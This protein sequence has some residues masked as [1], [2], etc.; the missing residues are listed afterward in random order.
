MSHDGTFCAANVFK[1]LAARVY[2]WLI[3][4]SIAAMI[5]LQ[6]DVLAKAFTLGVL[7]DWG[8]FEYL[9]N[10][11]RGVAALTAP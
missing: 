8:D 6:F 4:V 11:E 3:H 2:L 5:W 7:S 10:D 9:G 1:G